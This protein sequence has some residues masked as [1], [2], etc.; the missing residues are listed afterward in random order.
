MTQKLKILI[1][2]L[3][4]VA[5]LYTVLVPQVAL[6]DTTPPEP[7]E[8]GYA[9]PLDSQGNP[10]EGCAKIQSDGK[11]PSGHA[12]K[13]PPATNDITKCIPPGSSDLPNAG[14]ISKNPI[15]GRLNTIVKV[16]SGLVGV[17]VVGVIILGGIQYS[18]A[19]DKAEAVSAAKKRIINGVTALIAFLFIF[20]FLQWL[21][22]GGI[23]K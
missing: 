23:F 10:L 7:C 20:A 11:C 9:Y 17:V 3:S 12:Y 15:V 6:A 5:G 19:G 4:L 8:A 18:I 21:I 22:P 13:R 2:I 14:D 1:V 16:L